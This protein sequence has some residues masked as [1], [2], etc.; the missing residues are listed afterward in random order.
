MYTSKAYDFLKALSRDEIIEFGKF[1]KSPFH[2]E[3]NNVIKLFE[4]VRKYHPGFK[5]Q[6]LKQ[7]KLYSK[8]FKKNKFHNRSLNNLFTKLIRLIEDYMIIKQLSNDE[9]YRLH[10]LLIQLRNRKLESAFSSRLKKSIKELDAKHLH[11]PDHFL[12]KYKLKQHSLYHSYIKSL[13]DKLEPLIGNIADTYGNLL[14]FY[15]LNSY[16]DYFRLMVV[17]RSVGSNKNTDSR[18]QVLQ[19]T[20]FTSDILPE[21]PVLNIYKLF[22]A[23]FNPQ[24]KPDFFLL[25]KSLLKLR[26]KISKSDFNFLL[27]LLNEYGSSLIK[28]GNK[29]LE[30]EIFTL[31]KLI[32]SRNIWTRETGFKNES[33]YYDILYAALRVKEFTWAENFINSYS[34]TIDINRKLDAANFSLAI[35][36]FM[37]A[38]AVKTAHHI[39]YDKAVECLAKFKSQ[40]FFSKCRIF[41]LIIMIYYETDEPEYLYYQC[42][43]Y[44]HYLKEHV[45]N[46]PNEEIV[47]KLNFSKYCS[48]LSK[49]KQLSDKESLNIIKN[50]IE[51]EKLCESKDWLLKKANELISV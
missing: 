48:K 36:Y 7:E 13:P 8:V 34:V 43:S 26:N 30:H 31:T 25:K 38:Q 3:S 42:D 33:I 21:I 12:L 27:V 40:D 14:S 39:Y 46:I 17:L 41:N 4:S 37:K 50:N 5:S 35:L 1:I 18:L 15:Y 23:I 32:L 2:N 45:N 51:A 28:D 24:N 9:L 22:L 6:T 16:R 11:E 20:V 29:A 49:I 19:K 10:N 47:E 44:R